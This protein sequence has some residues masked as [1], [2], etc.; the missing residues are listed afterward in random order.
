MSQLPPER[1]EAI[2]AIRLRHPWRT[3]FAVVLIILAALFIYNAAFNR[4]AYNWPE[5]GKYVYHVRVINA[6]GYTLQLTVYSMVIAIVLGVSLAVM[7]LSPNPVVSSVAWVYLWV[8]RGTPVYVQ[9]T[10]WGLMPSIYKSITLG[11]PFTDVVMS[12]H[13]KDLLSYFT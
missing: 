4:P 13:T 9:L 3:V 8:F 12:L 7:R 2:E 1:A 6:I 5:V 10:F 11:I